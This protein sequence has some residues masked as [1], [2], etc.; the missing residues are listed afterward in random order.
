MS[1]TYVAT[2][3]AGTR[4]WVLEHEGDYNDGDKLYRVEVLGTGLTQVTEMPNE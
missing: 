3:A 2:N 4:A 1:K